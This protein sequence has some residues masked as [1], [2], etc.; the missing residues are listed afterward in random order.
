F[1]EDLYYRL[2]VITIQIPPLRQRK[3]DVPALVQHF[4]HK[5]A[6]ENSRPVLEVTPDAM[7]SLMD[8]DWPG[9]VREL[10][11]VIERGV[12]LSTT[13]RI[14]RDLIPEHVKAA[15]SFHVPHVTVPPEGISLRDVIA[16]F[17]RRLIESTLESTGWV[18]K[19]AA[20]LLGLKPTTLNEMIKR[21]GIAL[22]RDRERRTLKDV[23]ETAAKQT[24]A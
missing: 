8:Y 15:P 12:V 24:T 2:N 17:E 1:R 3:E 5:Y 16:G 6:K 7:Q 23:E 9:N 22:P 14:S 10:E 19:E 4:V 21:Y 11:N 13:G 18:Q 20:R